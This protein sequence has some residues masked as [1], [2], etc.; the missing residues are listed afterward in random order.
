MESKTGKEYKSFA[1][2]EKVT[3]FAKEKAKHI[4]LARDEGSSVS[5]VRNLVNLN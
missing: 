1:S 3:E 2:L 4:S 5:L